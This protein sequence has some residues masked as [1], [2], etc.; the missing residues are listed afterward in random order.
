MTSPPGL[1]ATL[2]ATL[3]AAV[4]LLGVE[5]FGLAALAVLLAYDDVTAPA[6]NRGAAIA[7]TVLTAG[8]AALLGLLAWALGHRRGWARGPG[9][10]CH[11][12][13]LPIGYYMAK[14]GLPWY[15]I[16]VLLAGLFGA[17]LLMAPATRDALGV[18]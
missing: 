7:V 13:L 4:V 18:R 9:I 10:F 16:P 11:L 8:V 5:G 15:G 17:G 6:G 12:M 14:G 1:P 3:R 2:P